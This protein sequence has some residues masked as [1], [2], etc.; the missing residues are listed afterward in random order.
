MPDQ[1]VNQMLK[2]NE[3]RFFDEEAFDKEHGEKYDNIAIGLKKSVEMILK[4]KNDTPNEIINQK[5]KT[6][7]DAVIKHH[8]KA[9]KRRDNIE[10]APNEKLMS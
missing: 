4:H 9:L 2:K 1:F 3:M 8:I 6:G 10:S 5:N 7:N